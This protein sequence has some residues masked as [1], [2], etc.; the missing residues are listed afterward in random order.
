[1]IFICSSVAPGARIRIQRLF[2]QDGRLAHAAIFP[3]GGVGIMLVVALR[4]AF[5][6]LIFLAEMAAA[7][8]VALQRVEAHQFASSKKSATRPAFPATGSAPRRRRAR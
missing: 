2:V 6:G 7:G 3:G 5:G 4:F 8:F 1:M